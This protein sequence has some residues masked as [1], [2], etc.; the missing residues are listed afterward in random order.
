MYFLELHGRLIHMAKQRV[1]A[2]LVT[3]RGLAKLCGLSQPHIH[4]LLKDIRSL[5]PRSADMLLRGLGLT[6]PDLL[7][8]PT[9]E[10]GSET[11]SIPVVRT[12]V[13]PGPA[14]DFGVHR[15]YMPLPTALVKDSIEPLLVRLAPDLALPRVFKANDLVLLDQN[16][17]SRNA[18]TAGSYWVIADGG[19]LRLRYLRVEKAGLFVLREIDEEHRDGWHPFAVKAENVSDFVRA[20]AVWIGRELGFFAPV[21]E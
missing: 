8:A 21:E 19:G 6:I 10:E 17:I 5:T 20:R 2:G 15:G 3:E 11:R 12:A 7:W 18:P 9:E 16:R 13:G 1:R 14:A 4:N